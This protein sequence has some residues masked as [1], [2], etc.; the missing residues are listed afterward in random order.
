MLFRS[1]LNWI[2]LGDAN[3]KLFHACV[4]DRWCK[5]FIQSIHTDT[6]I[7]ISNVNNEQALF[8]R[9]SDHLGSLTLCSPCLYFACIRMPHHDLSAL[10]EPFT[11][12]EI[13]DAIFSLPSVK[14]LGPDG[15]I[16]AYLKS[17]WEII[18][19][20]ITLATFHLSNH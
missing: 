5:N 3:S 11:E 6:G 14:A 13:R 20:D 18:K 19:N 12:K 7:A 9:F 2:R 17:C 10:E 8:S 4:S 1:R 16:G 15:F